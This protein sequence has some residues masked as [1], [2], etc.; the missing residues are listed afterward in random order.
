MSY[1]PTESKKP[2]WILPWFYEKIFL[3][4]LIITGG[5]QAVPDKDSV[6][7]AHN[8]PLSMENGEG[9]RWLRP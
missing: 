1:K 9:F 2:F 7:C 3:L 8:P 6:G 5:Y 4:I